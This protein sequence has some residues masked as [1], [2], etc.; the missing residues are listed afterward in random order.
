T[1]AG[2]DQRDACSGDIPPR[3]AATVADGNASGRVFSGNDDDGNG[4]ADPLSWAVLRPPSAPHSSF[5]HVHPPSFSLHLT[6]YSLPVLL[7]PP[8]LRLTERNSPLVN[9]GRLNQGKG[10]QVRVDVRGGDEGG[11]EG[12]RSAA[13]DDADDGAGIVGRRSGGRDG[14]AWVCWVSLSCETGENGATGAPAYAAVAPAAEGAA[15]ASDNVVAAAAAAGNET[16]AAAAAAVREGRKDLQASGE[17]GGVA[18]TT[19]S[20][21]S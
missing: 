12:G 14:S 16:A 10:D 3:P 6:E 1:K 8:S 9:P 2:R 13:A 20:Q 17:L 7:L 5:P 19:G 21:Q 15:D 11:D 18:W 4:N